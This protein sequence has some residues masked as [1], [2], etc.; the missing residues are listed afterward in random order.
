MKSA[1][2]ILLRI[3]S[4]QREHDRRAH[5]DI[6]NLDTQTLLKHMTLHFLKYAGK[7]ASARDAQDKEALSNTLT[8]TV[9]ICL[10]T[11]NALNVS[12]G[13]KITET[14]EDLNALAQHLARDLTVGEVYEKT[15]GDLVKISGRMAK[16]IESTDHLEKGDPRSEMEKLIV[17]LTTAM[18]A[19]SGSLRI[20]LE[21]AIK[22]RWDHVEAKSI[23]SRLSSL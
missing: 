20:P 11:A 21:E 2:A 10:A 22:Q 18:L 16:A 1:E 23:F 5:R 13:E 14:G 15:L 17:E 6:L 7:V 9:I 3:Q 8:D 12:L 4:E 19:N